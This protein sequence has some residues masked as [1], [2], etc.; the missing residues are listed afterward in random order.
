MFYARTPNDKQYKDITN[1]KKLMNMVSIDE[2]TIRGRKFSLI[3][4]YH[5]RIKTELLKIPM[6]TKNI[7]SILDIGS[8]RGGDVQKWVKAGYTHIVC[9]EPND[10]HRVEL[11]NR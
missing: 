8:G 9:V 11:K 5:N 10:K 1:V 4:R 7:K 6:N 3:N 2:D